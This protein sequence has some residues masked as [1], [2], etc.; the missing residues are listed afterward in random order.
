MRCPVVSH[1]ARTSARATAAVAMGRKLAGISV[2]SQR[3]TF[4][5]V[6]SLQRTGWPSA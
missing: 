6:S 3:E 4:S 5:P 1:T 2:V